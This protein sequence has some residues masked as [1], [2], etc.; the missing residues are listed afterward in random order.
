M[1]EQRQGHVGRVPDTPASSALPA[2][3]DMERML[4]RVLETAGTWARNWFDDADAA[5]LAQ[6]IG[7]KFW[8]A[9]QEN[10]G[11]F[12]ATTV[13]A[14]W[15]SVAV[16]NG[17]VDRLRASET[18]AFAEVESDPARDEAVKSEADPAAQVGSFELG[19]HLA[20]ALNALSRKQR[21]VFFRIHDR[22]ETYLEAAAAMNLSRETVKAYLARANQLMRAALADYEGSTDN[23]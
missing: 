2:R 1:H 16:R 18:R 17:A 3:A 21:E 11:L 14:E 10:P 4:G 23:E 20:E 19:R 15:I 12:D 7:L 8:V 22:D 5:D 13:P 9:W 6:D